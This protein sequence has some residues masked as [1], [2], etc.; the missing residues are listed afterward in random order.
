MF[1]LS[2]TPEQ[3][4]VTPG[5]K[6][7]LFDTLMA[8][9]GSL[10]LPSPAWVSYQHQARLVQKETHYLY[11]SF[12]DRYLVTPTL[13]EETV[14]KYILRKKE[15]K[16]LLLNYPSNP[17]GQTYSKSQLQALADAVYE[18]NLVVLSDEIYALITYNGNTH[19]SI[20]E[21]CPDR[22]IIF[23]GLSKDRSLGGFR[24]GLAILP[25]NETI[26]NSILAFGSETWSCT[27]AP[28]Q[29]MAIE[30]YK[31]DDELLQFIRD[32]TKIH[33]TVT[34]YVAHRLLKA[35]IRCHE[36][37]GAFYL[38]PDWNSYREELAKKGVKTSEDLAFHLLNN[39]NVATLPGS[40]FGRST[41]DL[42]LRIATVDYDGS[43]ALKKYQE[44][45]DL[46]EKDPE[47]FVNG[48]AP[49]VVNACNQ[50][51]EFTSGL[52]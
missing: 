32:C 15:Q 44:N 29:Y 46:V 20:A 33:E 8:L 6:M 38:F 23:S 47:Q 13:I 9:D 31:T 4:I 22:T 25:K 14:E 16:I 42:T 48:I 5:S 19:H 2:C 11:T 52:L 40:E 17:T 49:K 3:I 36:P 39:W 37:Q 10:M 1:H 21:F 27:A 26:I 50:L 12:E 18:H 30:A 28:I 24:L 51:E 35:G 41:K 45:K 7:A 43:F 34:N